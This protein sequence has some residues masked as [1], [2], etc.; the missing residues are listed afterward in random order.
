MDQ[1]LVVSPTLAYV[2]VDGGDT[3]H[4]VWVSHDGGPHWV[5][6]PLA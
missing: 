1:V 2:V 4:T 6:V 3:G 5:P